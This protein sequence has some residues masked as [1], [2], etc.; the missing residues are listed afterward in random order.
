M[1]DNFSGTTNRR[2]PWYNNSSSRARSIYQDAKDL[3]PRRYRGS[4]ARLYKQDMR[5]FL[6]RH[7]RDY[8]Q[9]VKTNNVYWPWTYSEGTGPTTTERFIK[10]YTDVYN[11]LKSFE[12][13]KRGYQQDRQGGT[14]LVN[15]GQ[16]DEV[17]VV[18]KRSVP[19][20]GR[21]PTTSPQGNTRPRIPVRP[22]RPINNKYTPMGP[23]GDIIPGQMPNIAP[24][25]PTASSL[26]PI[27]YANQYAPVQQP[28]YEEPVE[29]YPYSN[30][31]EEAVIRRGLPNPKAHP[32]EYYSGY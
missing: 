32:W 27:G 25:L 3:D 11:K 13:N 6:S 12:R 10:T 14:P 21:K 31:E 26:P 29:L 24:G 9:A 8:E 16:L 17:Q 5:D 7:R 2:S 4:R 15:G 28:Y 19:A 23:M 1:A 20:Q 22:H 30:A 18:A